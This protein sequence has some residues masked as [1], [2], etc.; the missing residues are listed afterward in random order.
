MRKKWMFCMGLLF[1]NFSETRSGL[2]ELW[3]DY[4]IRLANA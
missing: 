1:R 3:V 4:L 2:N